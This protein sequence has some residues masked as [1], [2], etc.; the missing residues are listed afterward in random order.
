[1][2]EGNTIS[3]IRGSLY[4][5]GG[6]EYLTATLAEKFNSKLYTKA[7]EESN[8]DEE[9]KSIIDKICMLSSP[10]EE[11]KLLQALRG[12][13]PQQEIDI[14]TSDIDSKKLYNETGL[15]SVKNTGAIVAD[16]TPL[17]YIAYIIQPSPPWRVNF[18]DTLDEYYP[19]TREK[20][21]GIRMKRQWNK[22]EQSA[23]DN[24]EHIVTVS[25]YT[26]SQLVR[27]YDLTS[28]DI[29]VVHPPN[30]INFFKKQ[31]NSLSVNQSFPDRYFF[32]PQRLHQEKNIALLIDAAKDAGEHIIFVG[33]GR[34]NLRRY[35]LHQS[36]QNEYIHYLGYVDKYRL[37][38]LYT[39]AEATVLGNLKE[40]FAHTPIESMACGTPVIAPAAGGS[41]ELFIGDYDPA[42]AETKQTEH[43]VMINPSDFSYDTYSEVLQEF[44]S[45]EYDPKQLQSYSAQFSEEQF[46]S[47]MRSLTDRYLPHK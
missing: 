22:Y 12:G 3:I 46:I 16:Q 17:S 41:L 45:T 37:R 15:I 23:L 9:F 11:S 21:F 36:K 44:N 27:H 28:D 35:V 29:S 42:K 38:Q 39:N 24:A 30:K 32:A 10:Q 6:A 8:F 40:P 5:Q 34:G 26:K 43:G 1:M 20:L 31:K 7:F 14:L 25:E 4:I 19:T 2:S 47:G 13:D 33:E 18:W